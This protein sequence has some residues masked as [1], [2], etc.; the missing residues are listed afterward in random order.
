MYH[1]GRNGFL[2][3]IAAVLALQQAVPQEE[4]REVL[5]DLRWVI[6]RVQRSKQAERCAYR[7]L[8]PNYVR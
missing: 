3:V 2:N 8:C 6:M 7:V 5:R 1:P 4:W